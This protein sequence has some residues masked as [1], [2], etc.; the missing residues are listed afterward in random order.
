MRVAV[1]LGGKSAER[2]VSLA[3]GAQVLRALRERGHEAIAVDME[4]GK[5]RKDDEDRLLG[6][7]I[8][9]FPPADELIVS[10]RRFPARFTDL[11]DGGSGGSIDVFFLAVH[12]G[13]GEDGT[14][15]AALETAGVPFTGSGFRGSAFA[16]DKDAAKRLFRAADVPTPDWLM[17]PCSPEEA[18]DRLGWPVIV[19]PN[20]Q[21]STVGLS[22]A[23]GSPDLEPAITAALRYDDE[24]MVEAF[25]PGRELTVG[26]LEDRALAVGEIV[27]PDGGIFDYA[28]KYRTGAAHEKFPASLSAAETRTIRDLALRA[29]RACK[30]RDYSRVDFRL[31]NAGRWWCLEVNSLPGLTAT[32]LFPQ[33]AAAVG[34]GFP[35]LCERICRL[36]IGRHRSP[37]ARF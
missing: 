34:I 31:D 28:T 4:R 30:L 36:A 14:L 2:D 23:K 18:G 13:A 10:T 5:M 29:H 15:Q 27:C 1:I 26:V 9:V 16:F 12:G 33:S 35:E 37:D 6:A 21:G 20:K 25:V 3:S 32:S 17:A 22:L 19:K 24:A 8:G 7:E 11:T